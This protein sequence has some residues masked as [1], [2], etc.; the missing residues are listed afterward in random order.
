MTAGAIN[1]H[2]PPGVMVVVMV[3]VF[4]ASRIINNMGIPFV[5]CT[6]FFAH[7][8]ETTS[9]PSVGLEGD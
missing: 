5:F 9:P 1:C 4:I 6:L 2:G 3:V 8:G 7:R